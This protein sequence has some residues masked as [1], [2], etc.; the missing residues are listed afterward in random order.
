MFALR[1][2]VS[3]AMVIKAAILTLFGVS[4]QVNDSLGPKEGPCRD[5]FLFI[6]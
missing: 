6:F 5:M 4:R 3:P 2:L 1:L